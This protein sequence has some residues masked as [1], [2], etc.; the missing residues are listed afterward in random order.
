MISSAMVSRPNQVP[1]DL[2]SLNLNVPPPV[3]ALSPVNLGRDREAQLVRRVREL[4]EEL[5]AVRV[6]NEKQVRSYSLLS[7]TP[8]A[9][10]YCR[11]R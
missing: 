9:D 7:Y 8:L 2:A 1:I 11:K 5:R 4:E 6:E 10:L 3:A